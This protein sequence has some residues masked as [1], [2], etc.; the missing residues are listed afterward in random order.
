MSDGEGGG[1]ADRPVRVALMNDYEVVVAGLQQMLAPYAE[2]V[3]VVELDSLLPV[4]SDV[5]VLLYDAFGRERVTGPVEQVIN[6]TDAKV[7]IYTWHLEPEL[8][9]EA[10]DKGAAGC[11]AKTM[12]ALDL[13]TAIEKVRG[14]SV[15]VSDVEPRATLRAEIRNGDWPGRDHG[16][17]ARESEVLALIAQG[18]SNQEIADRAFLSINSVKTYIRSAYRKIGVERRTQAVIWATQNGFVPT[19]ARLILGDP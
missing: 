14:G 17:S 15:V 9:Q 18:L 3:R 8:V 10:L 1:S 12:D 2:R 11:L 16:L 19:R 5:D 6:E 7:V 4:Y 13:V